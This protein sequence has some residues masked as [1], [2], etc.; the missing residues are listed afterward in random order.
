MR[1]CGSKDLVHQLPIIAGA[2]GVAITDVH[3]SGISELQ[4]KEQGDQVT[5][6][7]LAAHR[8]L[9]IV[10]AFVDRLATCVRCNGPYHPCVSP[11][12]LALI[13]A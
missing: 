1:Q 5:E 4:F 10:D 2:V 13:P 11:R 9:I 7:N 12:D 3:S 6:A 8:V